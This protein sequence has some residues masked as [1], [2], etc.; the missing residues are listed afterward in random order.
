[1]RSFG[2]VGWI[3]LVRKVCSHD[4]ATLDPLIT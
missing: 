2:D 3:A 1:V 4:L